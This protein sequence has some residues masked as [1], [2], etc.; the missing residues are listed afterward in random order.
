MTTREPG[1]GAGTSR[2]LRSNAGL[3]SALRPAVLRLARRLRQMRDESMELN[4][5]QLSAMGVLLN[6]GD[7]LMGELA[8]REMVQPPSMTRIVNELE[9]RGL[10]RRSDNPDDRRQARVTLTDSGRDVLLANR[11]RRDDW[12]ARRVAELD[13]G[14]REILRRAVSILEKVNRA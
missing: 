13:P 4:T 7:L 3:A 8:A 1:S 12:L 2:D 14:E 9:R 10:V 11:K 6:H 5:N